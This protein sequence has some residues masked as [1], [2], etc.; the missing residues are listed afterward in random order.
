[1][2]FYKY[3]N[4]PHLVVIAVIEVS[5]LAEKI[6]YYISLQLLSKQVFIHVL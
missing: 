5:E 6:P 3:G 1:L 2:D 4:Y